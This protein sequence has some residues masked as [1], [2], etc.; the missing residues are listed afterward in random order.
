MIPQLVPMY[1]E[2]AC[3]LPCYVL[4]RFR[5]V[6]SPRTYDMNSGW[7]SHKL[8]KL[9]FKINKKQILGRYWPKVGWRIKE[10]W[11][12]KRIR[13]RERDGGTKSQ[14][15]DS[16]SVKNLLH[17]LQVHK[18]AQVAVACY[19]HLSVYSCPLRDD[20]VQTAFLELLP[21]LLANLTRNCFGPSSS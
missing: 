6:Q 11:E 4:A 16:P 13:E 14:R 5:A 10:E 12:K 7:Y 20:P 15:F 21:P 8:H 17:S 9:L 3:D 2:F 1:L 18:H 19:W